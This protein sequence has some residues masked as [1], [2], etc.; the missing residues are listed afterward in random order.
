[1]ETLIYRT[2]RYAIRRLP[3]S[4]DSPQ[5]MNCAKNCRS[6]ELLVG[7]VA[8]PAGPPGATLAAVGSG[9]VEADALVETWLQPTCTYVSLAVR[10]SVARVAATAP[11]TVVAPPPSA[12]EAVPAVVRVL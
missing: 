8:T 5:W 10:P 11:P 2:R 3:I 7:E 4:E 9:R 12:T 1:M 6:L